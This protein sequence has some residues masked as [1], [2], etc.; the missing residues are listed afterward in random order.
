MLLHAQC[1]CQSY[2]LGARHCYRC[3]AIHGI[4]RSTCFRDSR[5]W[6]DVLMSRV[7]HKALH[8]HACSSDSPK[9]VGG[10]PPSIVALCS[11]MWSFGMH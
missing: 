1:V 9:D 5:I 3:R 4:Q 10:A 2:A 11:L 7:D 6:A 8:Y